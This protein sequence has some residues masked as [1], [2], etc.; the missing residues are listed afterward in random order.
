MRT[1]I[2][3]KPIARFPR[4]RDPK[5]KRNY[6][7]FQVESLIDPP[8]RCHRRGSD[9]HAASWTLRWQISNED[10]FDADEN[11]CETHL[12]ERMR[13]LILQAG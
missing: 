4:R 5:R 8:D 1:K 3:E 13:A 12:W 11:L 7:C 9:P 2:I 6:L 10:Y